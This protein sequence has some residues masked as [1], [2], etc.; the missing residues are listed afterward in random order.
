MTQK[1]GWN[2]SFYLKVMDNDRDQGSVSR[3]KALPSLRRS[4]TEDVS[5]RYSETYLNFHMSQQWDLSDTA[6][7]QKKEDP[8]KSSQIKTKW[9]CPS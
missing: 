5:R 9:F 2:S 3:R 1:T 6:E 8:E 7:G 4:R